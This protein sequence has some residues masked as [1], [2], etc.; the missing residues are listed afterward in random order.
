MIT[1]ASHV[2]CAIMLVDAKRGIQPQTLRHAA[3]VSI[4][5]MSEVIVCINKM[6]TV[7]YSEE[8]FKSISAEL[9][10]IF[11]KLGGPKP[12]IV[13]VNALEGENIVNFSPK[14]PWYRGDTLMRYLEKAAE[15]SKK[16]QAPSRT[17]IHFPLKNNSPFL[18]NIFAATQISG[19]ISKGEKLYSRRLK[20]CFEVKNIFLGEKQLDFVEPGMA[21]S[22]QLV[23]TPATARLMPREVLEVEN[24]PSPSTK[25]EGAFHAK[26]I[27]MSNSK[28]ELGRSLILRHI[29]GEYDVC[30]QSLDKILDWKSL[31]F[32]KKIELNNVFENEIF[33][34]TLLLESGDLFAD[35]FK[36]IPK[37]G[38]FSLL[39]KTTS[40]VL[41]AGLLETLEKK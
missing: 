7:N 6:D 37:C 33:K 3:I 38:S 18:T 14:M 36:T 1:G 22:L 26:I 41:A 24:A 19:Q 11:L 35:D 31:E 10:Q 8:E 12:K 4:M 23:E 39:E 40:T 34:A 28:V 13:P 16:K 29:S 21:I 15:T 5:N 25:I 17:L 20:E 30:I 2:E 9:K 32:T 27:W